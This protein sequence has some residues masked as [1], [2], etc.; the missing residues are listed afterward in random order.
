M[1]NVSH[2][3]SKCTRSRQTALL[4]QLP[5]VLPPSERAPSP[6]F[7]LASTV[8]SVVAVEGAPRR[9]AAPGS[10]SVGVAEYGDDS[11]Q[12]LPRL[13]AIRRRNQTP[14]TALFRW[15]RRQPVVVRH[16][17]SHNARNAAPRVSTLLR[18]RAAGSLVH[19]PAMNSQ[20]GSASFKTMVRSPELSRPAPAKGSVAVSVVANHSFQPTA[21]GVPVS[22]AER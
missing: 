22:A 2:H 3:K 12:R 6:T 17:A 18:M 15:L 5:R 21:P 10:Q 16:L 8:S 11:A 14:K 7:W 19:T 13:G 9:S 4:E 20:S 1:S